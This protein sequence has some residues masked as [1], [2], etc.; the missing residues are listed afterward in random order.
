MPTCE[1]CHKTFTREHDLK[2]HSSLHDD[3]NNNKKY[4]CKKCEGSFREKR[5]L[6]RHNLLVHNPKR[7]KCAVC[8]KGYGNKTALAFHCTTESHIKSVTKLKTKFPKPTLSPTSSLV[9][10]R[11]V[12][13]TLDDQID[14]LFEELEEEIR[15]GCVVLDPSGSTRTRLA[16]RIGKTNALFLTNDLGRRAHYHHDLSDLKEVRKLA[17]KARRFNVTHIIGSFPYL[18]RV[19][20]CLPILLK[21]THIVCIKLLTTFDH[22]K[23]HAKYPSTKK[24]LLPR[25]QYK[26]YTT[27]FSQPEAWFI[28]IK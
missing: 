28:W 6:I 14:I 20:K 9:I 8:K 7:F 27:K 1:I 18:A 17:R 4:K 25:A 16:N 10:P 15:E 2:R 3:I 21:L 23:I 5:S 22:T 26:G 24:I 11:T 19:Y 12:V 13:D